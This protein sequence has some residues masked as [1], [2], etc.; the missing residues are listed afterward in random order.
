MLNEVEMPELPWQ[1]VGEGAE[2]I[3]ALGVPDG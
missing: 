3:S 2:S 1:T